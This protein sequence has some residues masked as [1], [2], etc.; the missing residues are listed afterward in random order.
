MAAAALTVGAL[1]LP[2]SAAIAETQPSSD[3]TAV[4][5]S[6][7]ST[8]GPTPDVE[9]STPSTSSSDDT[10]TDTTDADESDSNQAEGEAQEP[11]AD[12]SD[13]KTEADDAGTDDSAPTSTASQP[14]KP[15]HVKVHLVDR[16]SAVV[17]W[18]DSD[19]AEP[20][21]SV[22]LVP[23]GSA[24]ASALPAVAATGSVRSVQLDGLAAG[25]RYRATVT[26]TTA[27]GS[28]VSAPSNVVVAPKAKHTKHAEDAKPA[29]HSKAKHSKVEH[30]RTKHAKTEHVKATHGMAARTKHAEATEH[31]TTAKKGRSVVTHPHGG[32]AA[33]S[34]KHT[35]RRHH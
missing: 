20:S 5:T 35:S 15:W 7:D 26:A 14:A 19:T 34:G 33:G 13:T 18:R 16:D 10:A 6:P 31:H 17:S 29:K 24:T 30:V 22:T 11:D 27:A 32:K 28:V 2:V 21:F 3:D 9:A 1:A 12:E 4:T 25:V 23:F 8:T